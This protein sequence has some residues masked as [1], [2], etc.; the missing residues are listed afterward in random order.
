MLEL[1]NLGAEPLYYFAVE[2]EAT[3]SINWAPCTVPGWCDGVA[4]DTAIDVPYSA[5]AF[6]ELRDEE[7][8]VYWWHLVEG[9][10]GELEPDSI[11][12]LVI[13]L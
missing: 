2:R 7:A 11:R 4:P 12:A 13:V 5:I 9:P 6:Y 1:T 3:A 10:G 8:V